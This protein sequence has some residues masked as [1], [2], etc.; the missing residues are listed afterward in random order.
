[1]TATF[2]DAAKLAADSPGTFQRPTDKRIDSIARDEHVQVCAAGERF[3]CKVS[4]VHNDGDITCVVDNLLMN[5][6]EHGFKYGDAI[7]V[8]KKNV[9]KIL[10]HSGEEVWE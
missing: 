4:K 8:Q 2:V 10:D 1:M 9:Y 5:V 7:T 3:W 6:S